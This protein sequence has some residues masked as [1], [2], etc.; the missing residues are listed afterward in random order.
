[1]LAE[2][3]E[4]ALDRDELLVERLERA[5]DCEQIVDREGLERASP[6]DGSPRI[7]KGVAQ[8]LDRSAAEVH[9]GEASGRVWIEI[10]DPA[11][12]RVNFAEALH[13]RAT[14]VGVANAPERRVWV[15]DGHAHERPPS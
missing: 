10:A 12:P 1:M 11:K 3:L 2:P 4:P 14:V 9:V 15:F 13:E 6:R 7:S 5:L 8:L